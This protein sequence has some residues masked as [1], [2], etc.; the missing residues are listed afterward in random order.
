MTVEKIEYYKETCWSPYVRNTNDIWLLT[1]RMH[2]IKSF[3]NN[4]NRYM[5]YNYY[6]TY[7]LLQI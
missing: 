7:I 1:K 2:I 3:R 5:F 4:K 6:P